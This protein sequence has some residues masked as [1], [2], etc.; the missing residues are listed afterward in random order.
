MQRSEFQFARAT[1]APISIT[2]KPLGN[3]V[4]RVDCL[5]TTIET[6][7]RSIFNKSRHTASLSCKEEEEESV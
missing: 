5:T 7:D 4:S 3:L 2:P 6:P 1:T